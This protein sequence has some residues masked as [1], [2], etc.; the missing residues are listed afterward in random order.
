MGEHSFR[1]R[2]YASRERDRVLTEAKTMQTNNK[3][4][5]ALRREIDSIVDAKERWRKEADEWERMYLEL[6]K[7][8]KEKGFDSTE[9][10]QIERR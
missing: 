5:L 2:G 8:V 4:I 7:F 3:H 10:H 1:L 6:E 9:A